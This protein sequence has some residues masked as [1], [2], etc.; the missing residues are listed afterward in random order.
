MAT[1]ASSRASWAGS[2]Q[3]Q[4]S[5]GRPPRTGRKPPTTTPPS[6]ATRSCDRTNAA[7]EPASISA[8]VPK[9]A[10]QKPIAHMCMGATI[11]GRLAKRND[12][13]G[14][15]IA[16]GGAA[17]HRPRVHARHAQRTGS[18]AGSS[19]I[20][21]EPASCQATR[22]AKLHAVRD[23][24]RTLATDGGRLGARR[25]SPASPHRPGRPRRSGRPPL[26]PRWVRSITGRDSRCASSRPSL[27]RRSRSRGVARDQQEA[28]V[29]QAPHFDVRRHAAAQP[30]GAHEQRMI[31]RGAAM[32]VLERVQV[33]DRHA[34]EDDG[35]RRG[36][37]LAPE[38]LGDHVAGGPGRLHPGDR[39]VAGPLGQHLAQFDEVRVPLPQHRPDGRRGTLC[40]PSRWPRAPAKARPR[41]PA[42]SRSRRPARTAGR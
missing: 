21:S 16:G 22:L 38:R 19:A 13:H 5:P 27:T 42:R 35:P 28:V 36:L 18:S 9:K 3:R 15:C 14:A 20:M 2:A 34:D 7:S 32:Q 23:M 33:A 24:S 1:W 37:R 39:V 12:L 29:E 10:P 4:A 25:W 41:G 30:A 8:T 31:E 17:S 6:S 11:P 40:R 26:H